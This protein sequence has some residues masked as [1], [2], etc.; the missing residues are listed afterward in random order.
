MEKFILGT[1]IFIIL[2]IL[3]ACLAYNL[4]HPCIKSHKVTV[5]HAGWWQ[6]KP[7]IWH[8]PYDSVDTVCDQ[9]K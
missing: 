5:H 2:F 1:I 7:H 8:A 4:A 6:V 9:R 3:G